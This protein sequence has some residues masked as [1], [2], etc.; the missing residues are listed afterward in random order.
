MLHHSTRILCLSYT[1]VAVFSAGAVQSCAP[2]A[3]QSQAETW[4]TTVTP[5]LSTIEKSTTGAT[6]QEKIVHQNDLVP[7]DS[8]AGNLPEPLRPLVDAIGQLNVGCTANHIGQGLV[9]T[10]GHC[11]SRSPRSPSD[12]CRL[13]AV[14][15][16][17]RGPE[18]ETTV[19]KCQ[20]VIARRYDAT[21]DYALLQVLNPPTA[22]IPVDFEPIDSSEKITM[23]SFP[24]MRPLEWSGTCA[25]LPYPDL[26]KS[27]NK[28]LHSCDSEG[29]SSGA[30][31]ISMERNRIVGVH[32]GSSDEF[33]YGHW[34]QAMSELKTILDKE[35]L[36]T[37]SY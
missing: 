25:I 1:I 19:S 17:N 30:A 13:M 23:L 34:T 26:T 2:H 4:T 36:Q 28:F 14:V 35:R 29:G 24:R 11:V 27:F 16:G 5:S 20:R 8:D 3:S 6:A 21:M 7:V 31:L 22:V 12:N 15:W 9:L 33:N 37:N 32:G 18:P 10:A